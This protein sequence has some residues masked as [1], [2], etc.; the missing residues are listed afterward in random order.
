MVYMPDPCANQHI[1]NCNDPY[2][3]CDSF[4]QGQLDASGAIRCFWKVKSEATNA[5]FES[6]EGK[7][8]QETERQKKK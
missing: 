8:F 2:S 1:D 5:K 3:P 4:K 7:Y 6:L